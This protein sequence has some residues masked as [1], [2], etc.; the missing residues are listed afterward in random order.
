L[1]QQ[2]GQGVLGVAAL[3]LNRY[4]N[5][6]TGELAEPLEPRDLPPLMKSGGELLQLACGIPTQ[7]V[8]TRD[9]TQLE[10]YLREAPEET[11]AVL[12]RGLRAALEW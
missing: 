1:L 11:R 8:G 4:I 2:V 5:A 12:L 10:H 7:I 3:A 6:T 9:S